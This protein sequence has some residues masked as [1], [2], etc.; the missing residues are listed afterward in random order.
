MMT[1]NTDNL[2]RTQR[3]IRPQEMIREKQAVLEQEPQQPVMQQQQQQQQQAGGKVCPFCGAMNN[4][5]AM[6]CAQCGQP[7][8]KSSCPFCGSEIDP[9]ADFCEA[10]HR[11]IRKDICSYCGA[12][13]TGNEAYCPECGSP[14]GGLV[15]PT[16]HT[17]NDF[18]FCKQ[19]GTPLTEDAMMLM[20]QVREMPEYVEMKKLADDLQEMD[21]MIPYA[22]EREKFQEDERS[23]LRERVLTLLA[24]DRG[25]P[26]PII[27]ELENKRLSKEEY[28]QKK[29]EYLEKISNL[30]DKLAQQPQPRPAQVRNYAMACR[31]QGVR[32]AW[33]CN[34][35]H[36]LHSSPCGCAKPQMGGKWVIL[37]KNSRKEIKDDL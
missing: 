25:T 15:C 32:L 33:E 6:F 17:M 22:S 14:R 1:D 5:E 31:P 11:Y 13:L 21:L 26:N 23:K 7:I 28:D 16:C 20:E 10:C 37:G 34:F 30:L 12:K 19:C 24:Q 29:Q 4:P 2:E 9:D 18:A 3:T 8:R 35:K 27:P 36:A